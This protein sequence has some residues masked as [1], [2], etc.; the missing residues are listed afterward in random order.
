M[1][2]LRTFY[3][4]FLVLLVVYTTY[5]RFNFTLDGMS[6]VWFSLLFLNLLILL[7]LTLYNA[8]K[9]IKGTK[10]F[11]MVGK[12]WLTFAICLIYIF[13]ILPKL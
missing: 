2:K 11:G 6:Y 4:V 13:L 5:M 8:I 9:G 3:Y 12:D 10:I 7:I 1:K